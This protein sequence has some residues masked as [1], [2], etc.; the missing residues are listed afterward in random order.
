M[1]SSTVATANLHDPQPRK[2]SRCG[3]DEV[4]ESDLDS[5]DAI[6]HSRVQGCAGERCD[7]MTMANSNRTERV[8]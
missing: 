1:R 4:A 6:F 7:Q 2:D 3:E 8:W 5:F